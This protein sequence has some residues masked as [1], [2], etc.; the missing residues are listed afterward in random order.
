MIY[1]FHFRV[2]IENTPDYYHYGIQTDQIDDSAVDPGNPSA[3]HSDYVIQKFVENVPT[4]T[5]SGLNITTNVG[6]AIV[7][8]MT[9]I[10]ADP[11]DIKYV[12]V[13]VIRD[14]SDASL[15]ILVEEKVLGNYSGVPDDFTLESII[16][17]F[18]LA[19]AGTDLVEV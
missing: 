15:S 3:P 1:D 12:Q 7:D 10:I 6:S 8:D 14:D 18:S 2:R 5:A 17:E 13:S 16:N 9:A 11:T 19:A 4:A